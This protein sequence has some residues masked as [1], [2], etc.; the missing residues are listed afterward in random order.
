[1]IQFDNLSIRRGE[2]LLFDNASCQIHPGQ[3]VGLTGANGCGKSSLFAV[4]R[5][6]LVIDKGDVK[7]PR[8]WVMAHVSQEAP[9]NERPAI[10][11]VLDG[12]TEWREL[13]QKILDPTHP[14]FMKYQSRYEEIDGY[15]ARSRAAQLLDGLGFKPQDIEKPAKEFS[16]G[17]RVRLNVAKALMCRS[18]LLLLDEPTNHLDLDAVLWLEKWLKQYSGTLVLIAHDRDFL[19]ELTTHTLH[20]ENQ[21]AQLYK[22]NYSAFERIR[23]E[24]L[25]NRQ[26]QFDKQQREVAHMQDFV[27]RFRAKATKATQ[28]QSRLKA[29]EKMEL[30]APA[31]VDSPFSFTIPDPEKNP[32]PLLSLHNASAGYDDK[33]I[34]DN[35]EFSMTPGDRVGLIGPNGAGKSTL[36]KLLAGELKLLDGNF[37]ASKEINI[38]YF[39]QHQI[40]QLQMDHSPME[41]IAL[42]DRECNGSKATENQLRRYLGSFGF[43]GTKATSKVKPFSGGEK[44]RL[45]LALIC[46]QRPN[47]LLL[48]EPTNHLDLEM[49]Q[50]LAVALQEYSGAVVLVSHDRHLLKV[51]SDKLILVA[52]G[53][54]TEFRGS[55][56]DYPKWL[57]EHN[58]GGDPKLS[59]NNAEPVK[60]EHSAAAKKEQKRIEAERRKEL[61]PLSSKIK[62][63][64]RVMEKLAAEKEAVESLLAD[65]TLYNE[66]NKDK[67]KQCLTDQAYLQK[68]LDQAEADWLMYSEQHEQLSRELAT[69]T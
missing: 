35:I 19:D 25:A 59:D 21:K 55:V 37:H 49:R 41:H 40:E 1:M 8:D 29:L 5:N 63:A 17:W 16:G 46:Y 20:I 31:H 51:N 12:D 18:D 52:N 43:S 2:N 54:A 33:V 60:L 57:A 58:R 32:S 36:I 68:E 65:T 7:I 15:S 42:L 66:D 50:A 34:V 11:H 45:A 64:E 28:A 47:L 27:R 4:L 24:Q 30:I 9:A 22:G 10:E 13:D 44:S 62:R 6:E 56:D 3:K 26:A 14:R 38:G 39:A 69:G 23:A 53:R 67:L 61:Q 48:D